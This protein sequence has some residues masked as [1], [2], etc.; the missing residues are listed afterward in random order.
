M[1]KVFKPG[2]KSSIL[3]A[4]MKRALKLGLRRCGVWVL[5]DVEQNTLALSFCKPSLALCKHAPACWLE[6]KILAL[7]ANPFFCL[8]IHPSFT[9]HFLHSLI[10]ICI[11]PSPRLC[12]SFPPEGGVRSLSPLRRGTLFAFPPKRGSTCFYDS[13]ESTFS[14]LQKTSPK[15]RERE[16]QMVRE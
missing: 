8:P 4:R 7:F 14:P 10:S 3:F 2:W 11:D 6:R 15:S 1:K 16:R 5:V 13:Q 9:T 12:P